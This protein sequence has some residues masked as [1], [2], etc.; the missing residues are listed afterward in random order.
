MNVSLQDMN[1]LS[2]HERNSNLTRIFACFRED[3]KVAETYDA[4]VE[5]LLED[6]LAGTKQRASNNCGF[7]KITLTYK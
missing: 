3:Q 1:K 4:N 7:Q 6:S 5:N 2:S